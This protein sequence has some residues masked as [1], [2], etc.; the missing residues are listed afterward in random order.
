MTQEEKDNIVKILSFHSEMIGTNSDDCRHLIAKVNQVY[1]SDRIETL[2]DEIFNRMNELCEKIGYE[3]THENNKSREGQRVPMRDAV[4]KCI[5]D[6]YTGY[7]RVA[8]V[9]GEFFGKDRTSGISMIKRCEVRHEMNDTIFMYHYNRTQE[10]E[11][12]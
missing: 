9:V 11:A 10:L 6:E 5:V 1:C 4:T 3:T 12:A 2:E 7:S 8:C